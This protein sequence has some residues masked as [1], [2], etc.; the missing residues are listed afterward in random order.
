MKINLQINKRPGLLLA[1]C[2]LVLV[3]TSCKVDP[4]RDPNNPGVI[5]L[6]SNPT[7][8]EIQNLVT[9]IESGMRFDIGFYYDDVSVIGREIYRFSQSDPRLYTDLLGQGGATLDDNTF[10]TTNP[11]TARY[12]VVKNANILIEGLTNTTANISAGQKAAG[13]AYA[14]TIKAHEL[15]M[16]FNLQYNH[17]VRI[18]VADPDN[19]GPFLNKD[20]SL[21]A[22]ISLL[23]DAYADLSANA[24]ADLPFTSTIYGDGTAG[25]FA[26]FNRALAARCK[27]YAQDWAGA[28]EALDNSFFD[29]NGDLRT[30]GYY[31]FSTTGGDILNPL[32]VPRNTEGEIRVVEP[33]FV[34][35]AEA[36]DTRLS[37]APERDETAVL[38]TAG[39]ASDF[40]FFLYSSNVD[41]HAHHPQ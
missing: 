28:L 33:S 13:I 17:G 9:G 15:L 38:S 39:L 7:L 30:G 20:Q 35:D 29:L 31:I 26:E 2:M 23:D 40:D 11:W 5:E 14:E 18:D 41:S 24:G 12:R 37:K 6:S 4:L 27:V 36:G 19:L 3:Q 25:S 21:A 34:D 1:F 10:Y 22:I 8:S 16:N 32:F